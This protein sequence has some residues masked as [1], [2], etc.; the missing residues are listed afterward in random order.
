MIIFR[1]I[2]ANVKTKD[3]ESYG[4]EDRLMSMDV[5]M[6]DLT[7]S[8]SDSVLRVMVGFTIDSGQDLK[9]LNTS[10]L[11]SIWVSRLTAS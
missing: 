1:K 10:T 2:N 4:K 5:F 9:I 6:E 3:P 7:V 8:N 11:S